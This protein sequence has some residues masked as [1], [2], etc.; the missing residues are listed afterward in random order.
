MKGH[1]ATWGYG[2]VQGLGYLSQNLCGLLCFMSLPKAK[3]MPSVLDYLV[4]S[5][6]CP[7]AMLLLA[8]VMLSL[9]LGAMLSSSPELLPGTISVSVAL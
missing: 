5:C 9:P 3:R 6:K 1:F 4:W 8:K 7:R 2:D